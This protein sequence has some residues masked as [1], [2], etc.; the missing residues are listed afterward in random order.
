MFITQGQNEGVNME[1]QKYLKT[2]YTSRNLSKGTQR[3]YESIII[4]YKKFIGKSL[5]ELIDEAEKEEEYR[6]RPR[7]R[8]IL[9][10]IVDFKSELENDG[11][12]PGT[13]RNNIAAVISFYKA[14]DIQTP[15]IILPMG[16]I[17]LE[18]NHGRLLTK[19]EISAMIA[20]A[21]ARDK[22]LIYFLA[23]TGMSQAEVRNITIKKFLDSASET[24]GK[25]INNI[26]KLFE[27]EDELV[28][29]VIMFNI[30]RKKVHYKYQT[31]LPPEAIKPLI[32]YIRSRQ[33]GRN[34][35]LIIKNI[36]QPLFVT[37]NGTPMTRTGVGNEIKRVGKL[38]GFKSNGEGSYCFWRP[39]GMR[40]YFISTII[41]SIGDHILADYLA[42]HKIPNIKRAYWLAGPEVL[43]K[44]I[45]RSVTTLID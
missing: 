26:D 17:G 38:A 28:K 9:G 23:L 15:D 30:I 14:F 31:F 7:K 1:E 43:K 5:E 41:N 18:K 45:Y 36:D 34:K 32:N 40:K 44:K 27:F 21:N 33:F 35:K 19:K 12:A 2:W 10:Y 13:L 20:V 4:K 8:K 11:N 16:D 22:A 39:H 6:I 25:D 3:I 29:E 24:I 42:G 37:N